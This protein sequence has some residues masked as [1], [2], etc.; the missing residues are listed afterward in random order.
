MNIDQLIISSDNQES[1]IS[2]EFASFLLR[3]HVDI[4][5][6]DFTEDAFCIQKLRR[7]EDVKYATELETITKAFEALSE[8]FVVI[9][10]QTAERQSTPESYKRYAHQNTVQ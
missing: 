6:G 2:L 7:Y 1:Q 9:E 3:Y 5:Y 8:R 4:D 10:S